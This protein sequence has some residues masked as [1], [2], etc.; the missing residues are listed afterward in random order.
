[1]YGIVL[2]AVIPGGSHDYWGGPGYDACR[3]RIG[4]DFED[5][6]YKNNWAANVRMHSVYMFYGYVLSTFFVNPNT[7]SHKR[8]EL[9]W[10]QLSRRV[11]VLRLRCSHQGDPRPLGEV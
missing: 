2:T 1:M 3:A 10:D 11:H 7:D 4:P 8:D 5:V 6:F 9:G